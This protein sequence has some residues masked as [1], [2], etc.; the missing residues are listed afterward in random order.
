MQYKI[1]RKGGLEGIADEQDNIIIPCIYK[2]IWLQYFKEN[3]LFRALNKNNLSGIINIKNETI[4]P[5]KYEEI[6]FINKNPE[7]IRVDNDEIT[8]YPKYSYYFIKNDKILLYNKDKIYA[9]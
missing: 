9:I 2:K 8:E 1:I 3:K 6:I 5:F 7:L 4:I